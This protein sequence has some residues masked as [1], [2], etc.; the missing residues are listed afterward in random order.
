S[1]GYKRNVSL[2]RA[3]DHRILGFRFRHLAPRRPRPDVIL[4]SMPTLELP[5][6]AIRY[7]APRGI[8]VVVDVRDLWPDIYVQG[9]P[10][11]LRTAARLALASEFSMMR[12]IA[13]RATALTAV[14]Q[15]YLEWALAYAGRASRP[16]DRVFHLGYE[17]DLKRTAQAEPLDFAAL[18]VGEEHLV[19]AF[20]G[21]FG[22]TY[23]LTTVIQASAELA[24]RG[25][26][27]LK[28]VLAGD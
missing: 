9:M 25:N 3:F 20:V 11:W 16:L 26:S 10:P 21:A 19:A 13:T 6:E 23:D 22:T 7:A 14:T 28:F 24:R 8:P 1:P 17:A 15:T 18:G 12:S 4:A 2:A 27:K 5:L